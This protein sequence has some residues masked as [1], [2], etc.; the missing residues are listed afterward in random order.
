MKLAD[1]PILLPIVC[2]VMALPLS[3]AL[4]DSNQVY[5][6][7]NGYIHFEAEDA[8]LQGEWEKNATLAGHT[9]SGYLEWAG[10]DY[11]SEDTAGEG[12]TTYHFTI[13]TAGNYEFRWRSRIA[14]G[15]SNTESNDSWLRFDTGDN[16]PGEEPLYGWTKVYMG[17]SNVWSWSAR[18]VDQQARNVRQY[19][20]EGEHTLA[21]SGRS[22]GHAIDR[23][24]L[25]RY[26]DVSFDPGLNDTLPL[27]RYQ[28]ADGTTIDPNPIVYSNIPEPETT[29]PVPLD[30]LNVDY[31]TVASNAQSETSCQGN[32]LRLSLAEAASVS[33][34]NAAGQ[35]NTDELVLIADSQQVLLSY[36][37]SEVPVFSTASLHYSTGAEASNGS[38]T[39]HLGSHNNWPDGESAEAPS[40][41]V[42]IADAQGGWEADKR[43]GTNLDATLLP[44]E[45]TTIILS[46]TTGSESLALM[47]ASD[48]ITAPELVL[49]GDS[50][51]CSTWEAGLGTGAVDNETTDEVESEKSEENAEGQ[52]ESK[53]SG[54][55][56]VM[57][58]LSAWLLVAFRRRRV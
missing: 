40:A 58:W 28:L 2:L 5:L 29:E 1:F 47:Q 57:Y 52:S 43:Y 39:I 33:I 14:K 41:Q 38:M 26:A 30:R 46:A 42:L 12:T 51:F 18:T 20:S 6:E 50:S 54:G 8:D 32:T 48:D 56:G 25:Y 19:L 44:R 27:S 53:K 16:V 22:Y 11:F 35:Y 34:G 37:L 4:A 49:T 7:E 36:D 24:A 13:E 45:M 9:G 23:I 15:D 10:A 17:E 21:I 3:N 31:I 55:G